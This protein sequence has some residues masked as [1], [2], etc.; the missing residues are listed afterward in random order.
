[1]SQRRGVVTALVVV[2]LL[3]QLRNN[4]LFYGTSDPNS[5]VPLIWT[6]VMAAVAAF[7][8]G[9]FPVWG[10]WAGG[11]L[12]C[13]VVLGLLFGGPQDLLPP[14]SLGIQD[15]QGFAIWAAHQSPVVA[16]AASALASA[17]A[18]LRRPRRR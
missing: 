13:V 15:P 2:V 1:M 14:S 6:A 4:T 11:T 5:E 7:S 16:A 8:S 17:G 9:R 10:L 18:S 12:A 3:L